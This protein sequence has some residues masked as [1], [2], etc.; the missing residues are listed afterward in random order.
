MALPSNAYNWLD[1]KIKLWDQNPPGSGFASTV[2]TGALGFQYQTWPNS[3]LAPFSQDWTKGYD[4]VASDLTDTQSRTTK[5]QTLLTYANG[6]FCNSSYYVP[7]FMNQVDIAFSISGSMAQSRLTRDFYPHNIVIPEFTISGQCYSTAHYGA[8][9]EYIHMA[10]HAALHTV[11]GK[12][13]LIQ[14]YL[15]ASQGLASGTR[16]QGPKVTLNLKTDNTTTTA[17][18]QKIVG[19]YQEMKCLGYI[20][21]IQRTHQTGVHRP[22]WSAQFVVVQML[23]SPLFTESQVGEKATNTWLHILSGTKSQDWQTALN[24]KN[25]EVTLKAVASRTPNILSGL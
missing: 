5:W 25:N 1:G 16:N 9:I 23:N 19:A 22:T 3:Q 20:R 8:L 24:R 15:Q 2:A 21:T 13:D 10:Q 11:N 4:A 12:S 7:L 17:T 14:F 6:N 18:N